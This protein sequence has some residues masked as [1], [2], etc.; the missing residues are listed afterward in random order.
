MQGIRE[1]NISHVWFDTPLY[2]KLWIV[3]CTKYY[4]NLLMKKFTKLIVISY[5]PLSVDKRICIV[6]EHSNRG[7]II[8]IM[9]TRS[10]H[11]SQ[12][13]LWITI[14]FGENHIALPASVFGRTARS[15]KYSQKHRSVFANERRT[16]F[17]L[18]V[19]KKKWVLERYL[20]FDWEISSIVCQM[21]CQISNLRRESKDYPRKFD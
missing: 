21:N 20:I 19:K 15:A 7:R 10:P 12:S 3:L 6:I 4:K 18:R 11:F 8:R 17:S 16:R 13:Q 2:K 1:N 5:Q 14:D 9:K